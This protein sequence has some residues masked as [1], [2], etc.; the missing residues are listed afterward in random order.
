MRIITSTEFRDKQAFFFD[1]VDEGMDILIQRGK[2]KSYKLVP[3]SS[4]SMVV[5]ERYI[6][7]PDED[8]AK[9]ITADELLV[10]VKED[11]RKMFSQ[12][13]R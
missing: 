8:L 13:R 7:E 9:A 1:Q 2:G 5:D 3:V 10:G 12:G 4:V 11:I 6:L